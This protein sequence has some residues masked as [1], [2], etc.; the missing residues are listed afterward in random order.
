MSDSR[1]DLFVIVMTTV[2][3]PSVS[4]FMCRTSTRVPPPLRTSS[5]NRR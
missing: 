1:P 2:D 4:W 5:S 3:R